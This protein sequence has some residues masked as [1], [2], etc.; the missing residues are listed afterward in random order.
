VSEVVCG[1][2]DSLSRH[3]TGV[4]GPGLEI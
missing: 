1:L 2:S 3:I 4:R